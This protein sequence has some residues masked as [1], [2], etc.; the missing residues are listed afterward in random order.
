MATAPFPTS[1]IP[2]ESESAGLRARNN[3]DG[4]PVGQ[5]TWSGMAS[6]LPPDASM[7]S[8]ANGT[9]KR[10]ARSH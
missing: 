5:A 7:K 10:T 2:A 3:A 4:L 8:A 6:G 1:A 9:E